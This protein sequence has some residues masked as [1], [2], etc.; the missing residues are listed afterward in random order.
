MD[1]RKKI[2][3]ALNIELR[4]ENDELKELIRSRE[5]EYNK[6]LKELNDLIIDLDSIKQQWVSAIDA[7][8]EQ[9]NKYSELNSELLDIKKNFDK[10]RKY[11]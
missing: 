6:K 1:K 4:K 8:N 7:L 3:E 11:M 9:R 10:I 5:D 2:Q